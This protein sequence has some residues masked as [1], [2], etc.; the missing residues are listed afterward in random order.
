MKIASHVVVFAKPFQSFGTIPWF[1]AEGKPDFQHFMCYNVAVD[2]HVS[3]ENSIQRV[4]GG[5]ENTLDLD[6][7]V[8]KKEQA[9]TCSVTLQK[10]TADCKD[11]V[12]AV[13]SQIPAVVTENYSNGIEAANPLVCP[14]CSVVLEFHSEREYKCAIPFFHAQGATLTI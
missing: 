2:Y 3:G 1:G 12:G 9:Q 14:Y 6:N 11:G 13:S 7:S 4:S 10:I 5:V 8:E